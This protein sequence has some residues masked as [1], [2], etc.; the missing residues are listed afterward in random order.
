MFLFLPEMYG[1]PDI[2]KL[3]INFRLSAAR[4]ASITS[5]RQCSEPAHQ[6]K[7]RE[8]LRD[9]ST[10]ARIRSSASPSPITHPSFNSKTTNGPNP[11]AAPTAAASCPIMPISLPLAKT[12]AL[13]AGSKSEFNAV[14]QRRAAK[15]RDA[16]L[17]AN[18]FQ[19]AFNFKKRTA[20]VNPGQHCRLHPQI[21]RENLPDLKLPQNF[22]LRIGRHVFQQPQQKAGPHKPQIRINRIFNLQ[23]IILP[24]IEIS[25]ITGGYESV[26]ARFGPSGRGQRIFGDVFPPPKIIF[27]RRHDCRRRQFR[28]N[29][30]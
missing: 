23:N 6:P 11:N 27:R 18:K 12:R 25:A 21:R 22:G 29:P 30:S 19:R 24:E 13:R 3:L 9:K 28:I 4:T 2:S 5:R 10:T 7:Y 20:A 15:I 8:S 14:S 17:P 1:S 26:I 16:Q